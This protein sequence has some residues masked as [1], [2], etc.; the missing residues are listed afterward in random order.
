MVGI[1]KSRW[2]TAG[3]TTIMAA[4]LVVGSSAAAFAQDE[5]PAAEECP[6]AEVTGVLPTWPS[7]W[8]TSPRSAWS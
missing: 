2:L 8:A 1:T 7:S 6:P 4:G 5:S 3:L